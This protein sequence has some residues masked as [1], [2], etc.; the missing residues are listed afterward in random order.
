MPVQCENGIVLYPSLNHFIGNCVEN[1]GDCPRKKI[2]PPARP[3]LCYNG[4][5]ASSPLFCEVFSLLDL[6]NYPLPPEP[7]TLCSDGTFKH[8]SLC[9]PIRP[10][11]LNTPKRCPNGMCVDV[12]I[13]C[14]R[15]FI[16]FL[17][18]KH[19]RILSAMY[20][21]TIEEVTLSSINVTS[22]AAYIPVRTEEG[23]VC[24]RSDYH[25]CD[26]GVCRKECPASLG[27]SLSSLTCS[28]TTCLSFNAMNENQVTCKGLYNCPDNMYRYSLVV[29]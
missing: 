22:L 20:A 9:E 25:I 6:N 29:M 5:C 14:S 1:Q 16:N 8:I 10:C 23:Y 17:G 24:A 3:Y 12:N 15:T 13:D 4:E 2:C 18:F 7:I 19:P 28:D 26:D 27:C 21:S 11:P